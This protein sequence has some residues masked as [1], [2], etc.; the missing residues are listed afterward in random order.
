M[1]LDEL[2]DMQASVLSEVE[3]SL[4]KKALGEIKVRVLGK[5]GLLTG[6]LR[7]MRE[8]APGERPK[9]G[10]IINEVRDRIEARI[11]EKEK[12]L[13]EA[14]INA[15]LEKDKI[16]ITEPS[17]HVNRGALHPIP[18]VVDWLTD[19]CFYLGF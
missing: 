19:I 6:L 1:L 7:G 4:D 16:D 9:V 11:A 15:K 12:E 2:N 10:A 17:K 13:L 8:L 5:A 14:E 3:S 18:S